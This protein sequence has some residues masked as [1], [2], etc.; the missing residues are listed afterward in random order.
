MTHPL[1]R[2]PE[3]TTE[4]EPLLARVADALPWPLMALAADG[5]VLYANWAA[6]Q[7]LDKGRP[8]R[9]DALGRVVASEVPQPVAWKDALDRASAGH[10]VPLHWPRHPLPLHGTLQG[11]PNPRGRDSLLLTLTPPDAAGPDIGTFAQTFQLTPAEQRV[12][13][14]LAAGADAA[15]VVAIFG[16]STSY[17]RLH[18]Q[19]LRRKT[20]HTTT[21]AL[22]LTI[23]RLPPALAGPM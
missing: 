21:A 15:G 17:V 7:L 4:A 19:A 13:S 10:S 9:R 12:L 1:Q 5:W 3:L 14:L 6:E 8:L 20:G 16:V 2:W 22:L 18:L 11:L 23:S